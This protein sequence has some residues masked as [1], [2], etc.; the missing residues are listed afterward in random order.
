MKF[1]T[2][3]MFGLDARISLT[4]F[5]ALSIISGAALYS[6]IGKSQA[7]ALVA[8]LNE[9]G[10]AWEQFYLDTGSSFIDAGSNIYIFK[11]SELI[12]DT[13]L[14][15]WNGP[16]LNYPQVSGVTLKHSK[17]GSLTLVIA[18]NSNSW[19]DDIQWDH[20]THGKCL[21]GL[22]CSIWSIIDGIESNALLVN[23]DKIVDG[24]N[25]PKDGKF[26]WFYENDSGKYRALLKI[27]S[28]KNPN[29]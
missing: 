23:A 4:I 21:S 27:A 17:Y 10:K 5:G 16:Y 25:S 12:T 28:I 19:G 14:N 15:G 11:A 29:D 8:E 7:T 26:K 13:G 6:A 20:L 1:N 22:K 3:A 24:S 18:N 2:G 9:I